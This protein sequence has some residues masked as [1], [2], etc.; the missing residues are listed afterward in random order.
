M[1]HQK[2]HRKVEVGEHTKLLLLLLPQSEHIRST[3]LGKGSWGREVARSILVAGSIGAPAV[4]EAPLQSR[5]L[6]PQRHI[7]A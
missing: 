4:K 1:L 2:R 6:L 3:L 5:D 7:L